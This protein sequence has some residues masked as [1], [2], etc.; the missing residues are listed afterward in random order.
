MSNYVPSDSL[1]ALKMDRGDEAL[2]FEWCDKTSKGIFLDNMCISIHLFYAHLE[3]AHK[4][5]EW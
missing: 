2:M 1:L 3:F 5:A 4:T